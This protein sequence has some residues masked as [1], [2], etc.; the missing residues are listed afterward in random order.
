MTSVNA[1]L[2][3][4]KTDAIRRV[5]RVATGILACLAVVYTAT[6][7]VSEPGY[8][9]LLIRA[10]A[11]AGMVGGIADWFAVEALFRHPLSLPI[12]HTALLPRNQKR[13][14]TNIARFIDEY[15]LVPEQLLGQIQKFNPTHKLAL[16]LADRDNAKMVAK[17]ISHLLQLLLKYQLERGV[18]VGANKAIRDFLKTSVQ[19]ADLSSNISSLLKD[20][21]NS[22]LM[23]D[24]L[25]EVRKVLDENRGKV[26]E[27]VQERSRW[28]IASTVDRQIVKVLVDGILSIIDELSDRES[29]L[30]QDF[31]ASVLHLV[32]NFHE[33]GRI[34]G[35]IEEGRDKYLD[36]P[37]FAAAVEKVI[38][39][40]LEKIQR[41]LEQ[42]PDRA[43]DL[44]SKGISEFAD[45]LLKD[46]ELENSLNQRL[47]GGIAT[48]LDT[49]R[50]AVVT[51]IT[52]IIE[53]W[54][55]DDL[56][57]RMENEVGRDLQFIRINGAVL[58]AFVGGT[59]HVVTSLFH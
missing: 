32:E 54:N 5:R 59:L 30:R 31:D 1:D 10:M 8:W 33:T 34:S 39:S 36:S 51:Y 25:A 26:T 55:S 2:S 16:W 3:A 46:A 50:P 17:E 21:V 53:D 43:A 35:F 56:V 14:A 11:E 38:A 58:G 9:L 19:P 7:A 27:I 42:D 28:R 37:E 13:A 4:E 12:P 24:I 57:E 20:T 29:A 22:R 6:F 40:V 48:I 52:K 44:I 41:N 18:G 49:V 47:F 45:V 23:D 15:F